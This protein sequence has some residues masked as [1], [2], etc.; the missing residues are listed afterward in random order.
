M[1]ADPGVFAFT[2]FYLARLSMVED[3]AAPFSVFGPSFGSSFWRWFWRMAVALQL[4]FLGFILLGIE[5]GAAA[6]VAL[7]GAIQARQSLTAIMVTHELDRLIAL[8]DR[9]A[10]L[11]DQRI[12]AIGTP[13]QVAQVPHPFI[14]AYFQATFGAEGVPVGR[15]ALA[16][17]GHGHQTRA[18][19]QAASGETPAAFIPL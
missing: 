14:Q 5:R 15:G 3:V 7:I 1:T 17:A 10:V 16:V 18:A 12:V 4:P 19:G 11:A 6:F 8:V 13:Q 9:V 2:R